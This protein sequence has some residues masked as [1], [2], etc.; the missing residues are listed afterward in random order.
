M[1]S[2]TFSYTITAYTEDLLTGT[3]TDTT[4]FG[5]S[6]DSGTT[7]G[8]TTADKLIQGGQ[9]FITTVSI[10]DLVSNTTDT[11]WA[12]VTA[13]DSDTQLSLDTDIMATGEDYVI[14]NAVPRAD[15]GVFMVGFK[16]SSTA[17]ETDL[18]IS[19]TAAN[20]TATWNFTT[21][22]DGWYAFVQ[23]VVSDYVA[24]TSYIVNQ[25]SYDPGS[26]KIYKALQST[27]G[28]SLLDTDFW[29]ETT[30]AELYA[31]IDT[32]SEPSNF[33]YSRYDTIVREFTDVA[34]G[35][36]TSD[37]AINYINNTDKAVKDYEILGLF[38]D[39]MAIACVREEYSKG[40]I[41]ARRAETIITEC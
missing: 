18:L 9:N 35:D 32:T 29:S 19:N 36:L 20:S 28:D 40:E 38:L 39:A 8:A 22:K 37:T 26:N 21:Q 27:T 24:L 16:V 3:L 41:I 4:T 6:V 2:L 23:M 11:S 12:K 25:V 1:G 30:A 14:Y 15:V 5:T 17:V 10:G 7:D 34:F 31:L 13:I 33:E